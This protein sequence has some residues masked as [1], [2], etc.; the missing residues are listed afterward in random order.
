MALSPNSYI[1]NM[2]FVP[3]AQASLQKRRQKDRKSQRNKKLAVIFQMKRK[4]YPL[5]LIVAAYTT[6][7][8]PTDMLPRKGNFMCF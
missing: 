6:R 3:K 5:S 1:Y 7:M 8:M 2:N 4:Q